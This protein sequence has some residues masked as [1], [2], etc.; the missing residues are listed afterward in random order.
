MKNRITILATSLVCLFLAGCGSADDENSF[1]G[2]LNKGFEEGW[3]DEFAK[4]CVAEAVKVGAP[5]KESTEMCECV[6][7][8]LFPMLDGW[9]ERINP[10]QE[11][12][13]AALNACIPADQHSGSE[14]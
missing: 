4:S 13:D 9:S 14:S 1:N 2:A 3:F 10:P 8:E 6:S 7:T 12:M 11:K 5:E